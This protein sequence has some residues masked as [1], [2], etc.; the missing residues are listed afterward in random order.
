MS[1]LFQPYKHA[2]QSVEFITSV[3]PN[4]A[5]MLPHLKAITCILMQNRKN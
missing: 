5:P 1:S 3:S 2:C 4:V